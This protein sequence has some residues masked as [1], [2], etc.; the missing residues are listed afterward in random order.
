MLRLTGLLTHL[1][2][3]LHGIN[4]RKSDNWHICVTIIF[5]MIR[6]N[7]TFVTIMNSP[8]IFLVVQLTFMQERIVLLIYF[9]YFNFFF[10]IFNQIYRTYLGSC[11]VESTRSTIGLQ[12]LYNYFKPDTSTVHDE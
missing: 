10:S 4:C 5:L 9:S 8:L 3:W 2:Y 6:R 1:P 12:Y 11:P 7:T